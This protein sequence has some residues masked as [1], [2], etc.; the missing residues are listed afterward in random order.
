MFKR[1][2]KRLAIIAVLL[3]IALVVVGVG[4]Q[5]LP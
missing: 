1:I 5:F 4:G 2:L 3:P